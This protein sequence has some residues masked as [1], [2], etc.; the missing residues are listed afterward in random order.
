MTRLRS[1][2]LL[3]PLVL[4]SCA[5]A[6]LRGK[7]AGVRDMIRSAEENGAKVC[8]PVELATAEASVRF[9][10]NELD[11]GD[12]FDAKTHLAIADANAKEAL[13][14]SPKEKC[15]PGVVVAEPKPVVVELLDSDKDGLTD[16]IDKCPQEPE[17]KD[18]F[19]DEDG[20]PESDN[21]KDGLAD[22]IDRCPL[23][24]E[25]K[26]AFEDDDGCP[27]KDNDND[28]LS[29]PNDACPNEAEDKDGFEDDDGCPDTDNDKDKVPDYPQPIDKCPNDPASTPDGC[30]QKYVNIVVKA[31]KIELKQKIFFD[32]NKATIKP[33]SFGL[34]NEVAKALKDFPKMNVRIE[35]HTDSQGSDS[36]NLK[37]SQGRANSVRTYL[38]GQ[39]ID[40]SRMEARGFGESVPIADNRTD[41]GR[42]QN[43]R[44]EFLITSQ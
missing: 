31:D 42:E 34:L 40:P 17:D 38:I 24:P 16:D 12:Y 20:C 7:A 27:D 35:G 37:L 10:G 6:E 23:D 11:R 4:G 36:K 32:T 25:D 8:A 13:R 43:R 18:N 15:A 5:G 14:K 28:G 21:D 26:D 41:A 1:I 33:V 22:G 30:P 19:E 2:A 3:L 44:V 39:G 29:D 9:A